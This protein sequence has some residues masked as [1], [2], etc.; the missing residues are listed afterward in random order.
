MP[1]PTLTNLLANLAAGRLAGA[2]RIS[3]SRLLLSLLLLG[4]FFLGTVPPG[5]A[6]D[7]V[8]RPVRIA[9][10]I[11]L[12]G[13]PTM[14]AEDRGLFAQHGLDAKVSF[15][16]AG[17][18]NLE[19]LQE[20][21][22]DFAVMTLTPL[23]IDHLLDGSR[24]G[25]EDP[26]I[27][28][29][30]I[31]STDID[32]I[33]FRRDRAINEPSDLSGRQVALPPGTNAEFLWWL[34]STLNDLPKEIRLLHQQSAEE[35]PPLFAA[36]AI[37]AAVIREPWIARLRAQLGDDLGQFSIS[38]LYRAKWVL[39]TSQRIAH[40]RRDLCTAVLASYRDAIELI[41]RDKSRTLA[42]YAEHVG[43]SAA[44]LDEDW[45]RRSLDYELS[46]DWSLIAALRQQAYWAM[47]RP[48]VSEPVID[49][50]ALIDASVLRAL[51]PGAVGIPPP[52]PHSR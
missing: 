29:G 32:R 27:L 3:A 8:L 15:D 1:T 20:G 34:F 51:L 5:I 46:V 26:V 30:L 2:P 10:S 7:P 40:E 42:L 16:D 44:D 14:A 47:A 24:G 28:A 38:Q 37:D 22:V 13:L 35:I 33:V 31:H 12:A 11:N 23:V 50:L 19:R 17:E 48:G 41:S 4:I 49:I 36:G 21:A 9:T 43:L 18:R 52:V 6:H 39:V 45:R 25:S